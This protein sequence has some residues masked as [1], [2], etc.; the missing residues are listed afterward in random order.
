MGHPQIITELDSTDLSQYFG[1]VKCTVLAPY[2][3]YMPMLPYRT[4]G[5]LLFPLCRSGVT[6]EMAKPLL[7]RS[8]DCPH[9]DSE[10]AFIG[11]RTTIEI[12]EAL[13]RAMM[14]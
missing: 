13:S 1:L 2:G 5:K 9:A 3:L 14:C 8:P 4:H 12:E 11:T 6:E 10:R 7:E